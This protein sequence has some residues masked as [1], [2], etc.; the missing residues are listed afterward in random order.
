MP[1]GL[2]SP[3]AECGLWAMEIL[4]DQDSEHWTTTWFTGP[5]QAGF[6][7]VQA[8][9]GPGALRDVSAFPNPVLG[10]KATCH[11]PIA[12]H[13]DTKPC[14]QP[15]QYDGVALSMA[16]LLLRAENLACPLE[17]DRHFRGPKGCMLQWGRGRRTDALCSQFP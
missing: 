8:Q 6:S 4:L 14:V 17:I 1:I 9:G 10:E 2:R 13:A 3:S 15:S 5:G 7:E 11:S 16:S 12:M